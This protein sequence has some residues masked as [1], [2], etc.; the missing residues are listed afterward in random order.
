MMT[1]GQSSHF[2]L[3]KSPD[4][5]PLP[6]CSGLRRGRGLRAF[7]ESLDTCPGR[8]PALPALAT[9]P[10]SEGPA[11]ER[12]A[13]KRAG[14]TAGLGGDRAEQGNTLAV[15]SFEKDTRR[16]PGLRA[17]AR[18]RPGPSGC[19]VSAAGPFVLVGAWYAGAWRSSRVPGFAADR[20]AVPGPGPVERAA[21]TSWRPA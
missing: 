19:S 17:A 13:F 3:T 18:S 15:L 1:C 10:D 20:G 21:S 2:V 4:P 8:R 16:A 7:A 14:V 12:R 11:R 6:R 9:S 5:R